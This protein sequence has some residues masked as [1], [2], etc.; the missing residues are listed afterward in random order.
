MAAGHVLYRRR[1]R[2]F[3]QPRDE[4]VYEMGSG[5]KADSEAHSE[6]HFGLITAKFK[7]EICSHK[8]AAEVVSNDFLA[9]SWSD[10]RFKKQID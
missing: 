8:L 2:G 6:E 7:F 10:E 3:A 1:C 5:Y 4:D 9:N